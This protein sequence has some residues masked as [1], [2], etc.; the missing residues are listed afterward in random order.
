MQSRRNTIATSGA[1]QLPRHLPPIHDTVVRNLLAERELFEMIA[2][3]LHAIGIAEAEIIGAVPDVT[4]L[5]EVWSATV[6]ALERWRSSLISPSGQP[7][8][9]AP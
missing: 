5:F 9:L 7:R 1:A 6:N 2:P 4:T 3:M 8:Y